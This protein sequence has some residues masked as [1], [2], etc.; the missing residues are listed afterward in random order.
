M[1]P[2]VRMENSIS[3]LACFSARGFA[4]GVRGTSIVGSVSIYGAIM[5]PAAGG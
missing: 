3:I 5:L 1:G 4:F 2:T